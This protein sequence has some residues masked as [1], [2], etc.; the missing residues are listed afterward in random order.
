MELKSGMY[1]LTRS[2][3]LVK[4]L[5]LIIGIIVS[6]PASADNISFVDVAAIDEAKFVA[7]ARKFFEKEVAADLFATNAENQSAY[8]LRKSIL[9]YMK[10]T[11]HEISKDTIRQ[12][13]DEYIT[14]FYQDE[15]VFNEKLK[16]LYLNRIQVKNKFI[17]NLYLSDYFNS[18]VTERVGADILKRKE[19]LTTVEGL[20]LEITELDFREYFLQF[21]EYFGGMERFNAFMSNYNL[22]AADMLFMAQSNMLSDRY[23]KQ[24]ARFPKRRNIV[25]R[26]VPSVTRFH[27]ISKPAYYV[28]EAFI[29]KSEPDAL[30]K[31]ETART[32]FLAEAKFADLDQIKVEDLIIPVR[33]DSNLYAAPVKEAVLRLAGDSLFVS[34]NISPVVESDKA[35]HLFKLRNI[36]INRPQRAGFALQRDIARN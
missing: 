26:T 34:N 15:S 31:L 1:Y 33:T 23:S 21:V 13:W 27:R 32:K 2:K 25:A 14:T 19:L 20:P 36:E 30:Q 6:L 22:T 16:R 11:G 24:L 28:S 7:I 3:L 5:S 17:E 35:F 9:Q 18:V 4:L 29:F 12:K 10:A 8:P